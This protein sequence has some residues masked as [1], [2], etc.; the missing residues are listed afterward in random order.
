MA[1]VNEY[2]SHALL[3]EDDP[4]MRSAVAVFLQEEM[5]MEVHAVVSYREALRELDRIGTFCRLALVD[6]S[7]PEEED[8]EE[9][10]ALGLKLIHEI[11]KRNRDC[12]VVLWSAYTHFLP[13]LMQLISQGYQGLA[14]IPKGSR[15][16]ALQT[17]IQRVMLGDV[18]LHRSVVGQHPADFE[19][20]LLSELDSET[21]AIVTQVAERLEELSPRQM[22]V[23][24][25]ITKTPA[26]IAEELGLEVRT[27]RNYQDSIYDRLG[28]RESYGSMQR[29][30]R[31]P[32]VMLALLIFRMRQYKQ[33]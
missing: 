29:I 32:I 12:G 30:R 2:G 5:G 23:V 15:V 21:A 22:E 13:K 27:V 33:G 20:T 18:F 1:T 19:R 10:S 26:A 8:D 24:E 14:Y 31:D 17:A 7:L 9:R 3:V 4:F 11:K 6:V 28:L 16:E 25:R